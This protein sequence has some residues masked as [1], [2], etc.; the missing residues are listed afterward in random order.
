MFYGLDVLIGRDGP[1]VVGLSSF[2]GYAHVPDAPEALADH[3][4][5]IA[6]GRLELAPD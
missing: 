3:I 2:P 5:E 4:E 1:E 6:H